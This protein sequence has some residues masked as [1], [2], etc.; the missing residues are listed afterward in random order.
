MRPG[1]LVQVFLSDT[2]P[3]PG[4][5]VPM[6]AIRPGADGRGTVFLAEDGR[7]RRVDV[8]IPSQVRG[9]FRIE[10]DGIEALLQAISTSALGNK[11]QVTV[12]LNPENSALISEIYRHGTILDT[13]ST[14]DS[15]QITCALPAAVAD[16]LGLH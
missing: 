15:V 8:R 3:Q 13:I 7:A 4:L 16:R 6:D 5:Y 2:V 12:E 10:G 9:L 14:E 1:Q 11:V